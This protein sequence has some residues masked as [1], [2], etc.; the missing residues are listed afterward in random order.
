MTHPLY[1]SFIYTISFRGV[2]TASPNFSLL[3]GTYILLSNLYEIKECVAHGSNKA[4]SLWIKC[5]HICHHIK[6]GPKIILIQIIHPLMSPLH[7]YSRSTTTSTSSRLYRYMGF[8][9]GYWLLLALNWWSISIWFLKSPIW[10]TFFKVFQIST[11]V[12]N[13]V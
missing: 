2:L 8:V 1:T 4:Y 5:Y 7:L 3:L 10:A 11:K 12:I 6:W 13:I 9:H